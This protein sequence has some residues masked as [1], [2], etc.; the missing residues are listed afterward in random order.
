MVKLSIIVPVYNVEKYLS[1]CI[2][3]VINQNFKDL[4]LLLINDGSTDNSDKIC[5]NYAKIDSRIKVIHKTNS[6]LSDAR[7]TG[8]K[9]SSGEYLIFIDSDDFLCDNCLEVVAEQLQSSKDIEILIMSYNNYYEQIGITKTV[10][11]DLRLNED[12]LKDRVSVIKNYICCSEMVWPAP[13]YIVKKQ[14]ILDNSMEF[15]S[16]FLHEDVDWTTRLFL[17]VQSIKFSNHILFNYRMGRFDSIMSTKNGRHICDVII[18]IDDILTYMRK[19]NCSGEIRKLILNKL[20]KS[21]FTTLRYYKYCDKYMKKKVINMLKKYK[22]ILSYSNIIRHRLFVLCSKV[23]GLRLA[24][25]LY[26]IFI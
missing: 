24:L 2:D 20:S 17:N 14:F 3:S 21:L 25:D 18:I 15:K 6:G 26:V 10:D 7:N 16:G 23:I 8:I 4:E 19:I 12:D 1:Q 22:Y 11:C 13:R 5:D 9:E